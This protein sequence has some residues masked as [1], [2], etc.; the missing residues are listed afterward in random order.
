MQ[1]CAIDPAYRPKMRSNQP[2][3]PMTPV[4]PNSRVASCAGDSGGPLVQIINGEKRLLGNTSWGSG[5]CEPQYPAC[6]S[7][8][9]G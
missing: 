8:N 1:Q 4:H 5:R 3:K 7:R 6:W 9:A 2:R